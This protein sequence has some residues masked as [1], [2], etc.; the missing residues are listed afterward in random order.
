MKRLKLLIK[1]VLES[2]KFNQYEIIG[3][4]IDKNLKFYNDIDSQEFIK[5]DKKTKNIYKDI[6][7]ILRS[8]IINTSNLK[9]VYFSDF[10][11]G[12]W[13]GVPIHWSM[14]DIE[15]GY[16]QIEDTYY[17]FDE[18]IQMKSTIKV[19]FVLILNSDILEVTYN[20]YF[21]FP[22]F[23]TTPY[24]EKTLKKNYKISLFNELDDQHYYKAYKYLY[25]LNQNKKFA[26]PINK[27]GNIIK[28]KSQ[29]DALDLIKN[30]ISDKTYNSLVKKLKLESD[31]SEYIEKYFKNILNEE[32]Y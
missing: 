16:I 7:N 6:S 19:D 12:N 10:K 11:L 32:H 20:Y 26:N 1:N 23:S 24:T 17:D 25:K 15:N 5:I 21:E 18:C 28:K 29:M 8:K 14:E 13:K 9:N 4:F 30:Q 31:N 3:S 27:I 2:L 22:S